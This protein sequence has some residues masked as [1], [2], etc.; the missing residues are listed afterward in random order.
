MKKRLPETRLSS[1]LNIQPTS[2][3]CCR[4]CGGYL[5]SDTLFDHLGPH[6]PEQNA[7]RH[8]INCGAIDDALIRVNR[9]RSRDSTP[10]RHRSGARTPAT[11]TWITH[12][13][14][15]P[16]RSRP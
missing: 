2:P 8:C 11:A 15:R 12:A 9:R 3:T 16:A 13:S 5:V 7:C 6:W 14:S 4:R 10:L 1:P